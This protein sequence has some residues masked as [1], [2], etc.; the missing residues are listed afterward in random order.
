MVSD[1]RLLRDRAANHRLVGRGPVSVREAR[2]TPMDEKILDGL[3]LFDVNCAMV[4]SGIRSQFPA[5]TEKQVEQ[6]FR[7][8]LAIA[9]KIDDAGI[10]RDIESEDE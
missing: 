6:E 10:Y 9:R 8:R 2:R 5:F 4:R 3:R 1:G 7:R